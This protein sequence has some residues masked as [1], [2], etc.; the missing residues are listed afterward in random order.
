VEEDDALVRCVGEDDGEMIQG[1]VCDQGGADGLGD[2][3]WVAI[4]FQSIDDAG[5]RLGQ[6][7]AGR[8]GGAGEQGRVLG[9]D[10]LGFGQVETD[11]RFEIGR[12]TTSSRAETVPMV[13]AAPTGSCATPSMRPTLDRRAIG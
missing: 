13:R 9:G 4:L 5:Q 2:R 1:H 6:E 7:G 8:A 10:R 11:R 12:A 3:H